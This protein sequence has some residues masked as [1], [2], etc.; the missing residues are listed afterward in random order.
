[1]HKRLISLLVFL[2]LT[3]LVQCGAGGGDN[4]KVEF[5]ITP[6]SPIVIESDMTLFPG[7]EDR[8]RV[9]KGPWFQFGFKVNNKSSMAVTIQSFIFNYS[10]V[11]K[12]GSPISGS[13]KF[14]PG[15]V[16]DGYTYMAQVLKNTTFDSTTD[17]PET[18][19][20]ESLPAEAMSF[21]YTVEVKVQG[22]FGTALAP[23][24]RLEKTA[25]FSTK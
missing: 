19:Y 12:T 15:Q 21:Y 14:D 3:G 5:E 20:A 13:F 9:L 16:G 2:S 4:A 23:I 1:M 11:N 17:F 6:T 25:Y 22:W 18:L 24:K 8:E 7:D 10:G